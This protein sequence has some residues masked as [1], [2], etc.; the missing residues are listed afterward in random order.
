ME[1]FYIS[2]VYLNHFLYFPDAFVGGVI[3]LVLAYVCYRQHYPP[4]THSSCH[5]PSV[6]LHQVSAP[7]KEEPEANENTDSL[8]HESMTEGPV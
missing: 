1:P 2:L 8:M 7:K 3:G 5:R 6:S 4:L